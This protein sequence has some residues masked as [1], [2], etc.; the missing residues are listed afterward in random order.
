MFKSGSISRL[1][2]PPVF[3]GPYK[4]NNY[5]EGWYFKLVDAG[6]NHIWSV[7]PG[8]SYS[9]DTH[10]FIQVI[11][12]QTGKTYYQRF[13]IESFKSEKKEFRI[14]IG[15]NHFSDSHLALDLQCE[16]MKI[17]GEVS[18]GGVQPFPVRLL[19]PG[20]MGWYSF[21]PF[22]EC[23]HGVVS[24]QHT[25]RGSLK[26]NESIISFDGGRG[27]IEKDWGRSMPTDWIWMQSNHFDLD[28]KVSF[29]LSVARI[30]WLNG[31]FPGFLSFLQLQGK[32]YR[33]ATY[34]GSKV[35][36]LNVTQEVVKVVLR[37]REHVLEIEALR[38]DGGMLKAPRHGAMDREIQESIISTLKLVLK[39]R[40]GEVLH[41][42]TGRYAGLEIV[43]DMEQYY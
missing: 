9:K 32:V 16:D 40:R 26:V 2:N 29:M 28:P 33:F 22:M 37:N 10:S 1:Y 27:Y 23:Y 12:A 14:K 25:L 13:P 24:M 42:D 5:F 30:P 43:G 4:R 3:Q 6:G 31:H 7:I 8:V 17:K 35:A 21:V 18:F 38:Q 36:S 39:N 20:I 19:S 34:N 15:S 11:H 41:S